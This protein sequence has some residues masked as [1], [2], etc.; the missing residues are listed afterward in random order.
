MH[1]VDRLSDTGLKADQMD[2]Y[3][4]W[5]G[6]KDGVRDIKF[7]DAAHAYLTH[8]KAEELIAV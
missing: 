2:Y 5:C 1:I 6:S 7:A 8:L 4:V 3:C